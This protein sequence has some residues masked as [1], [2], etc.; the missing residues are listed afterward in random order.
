[1]LY[2]ILSFLKLKLE[3]IVCIKNFSCG[4]LTFLF[5]SKRKFELL[6]RERESKYLLFKELV[7]GVKIY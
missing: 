2:I 7:Y 5:K 4:C 6:K 1:M 3:R